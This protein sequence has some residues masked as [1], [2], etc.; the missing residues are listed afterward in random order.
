MTIET[1]T[2]TVFGATGRQGSSVVRSLVQNPTFHVRAITRN[3]SSSKAK[4]LA[5][6]GAEL[7]KAD[8]FNRQ[9]LQQAFSGSWGAFVNTNSED[10]EL[11][12]KGLNDAD[13]GSN[14]IE[15]AA[16][17]GVQHLV[18][19][20]GLAISEMTNGAVK[21]PG[22]DLKIQVER[23]AY[24]TKGFKTVTPIVAAWFMENWLEPDYA[25]LFGGWPTFPDSEGYLTYKTPFWGGKED[26]PWISMKDDFGD[27]VHGVFVNPLRWNR[28][29]IQ[30]SSDIVSSAEVV[31][32]FVSVT[33][34]KARYEVLADPNDMNTKG[35][36]WREQERDVFIYSQFRDGEYFGNGPTEI[37]TAAVLKKAAFKAKGGK[38]RE[39]LITVREFMEREFAKV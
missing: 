26:F 37:Q 36:Y 22:L 12:A 16:S 20:S 2:I 5:S 13:L 14:I 35:E 34:K 31:N 24:T 19:S 4:E 25:D 15:C 3:P 39:T 28:R 32:T 8:G 30:G 11:E 6:L 10:P 27:L 17:S 21:C 1:K 33:G 29:L 38:G 9:E 7:V 18:Y 23:Q